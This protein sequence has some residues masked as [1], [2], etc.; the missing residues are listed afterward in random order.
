MTQLLCPSRAELA[1]YLGGLLPGDRHEALSRHLDECAG[2]QASLPQVEGAANP[3][4]LHPAEA[5]QAGSFES[6]PELQQALLRAS[7]ASLLSTDRELLPAATPEAGGSPLPGRI[8][9]YQVL[10]EIARGGM[11]VVYKARQV[12]LNRVVALKMTRAGELASAEETQRFRLEAEAA[13]KLDHPAIVPIYEVGEDN[14]RHYFSMALV[15]G[16]SLAQT[17]AERPLASREAATLVRQVAEA[18][19]YAHAQGVIHRDLK[20]GNIL[21][22][23]GQPRVTDFGLAKRAD[24]DSDLTRTGQI[25]GTPSYMAPEQAEGKVELIGPRSDVYALGATLYC[26]LTGRP[27]FHAA[28]TLETLRQVAERDPVPP[29]QLNAAI[30]PDLETICL[31][32]LEKRPERRY[33]SARELA[34]ELGRFLEGLPIRARPVGALGRAV[35]WWRRRPAIAGLS[36][37][38]VLVALAGVSAVVWQWRK[39]VML[40]EAADRSAEE[41]RQHT[42]AERWQRYRSNIAA[43]LSALRLHNDNA[44]RR[45]LQAAPEE[46]RNWEWHYLSGQLEDTRPVLRGLSFAALSPTS[47]QVAAYGWEDPVIHLWKLATGQRT[48]L[49]GHEA[50]VSPRALNYSPDGTRIA[51]G[52]A[53]RT[54]RLW[55]ART[56]RALAVLRGHTGPVSWVG[57]SPDGKRIASG[58]ASE[59]AL[60]LWD[61]SGISDFRF[62]ISDLFNLKSEIFNLKSPKVLRGH[63]GPVTGLI[64]GAAARSWVSSSADGTVRIW[65]EKGEAS[66]VL[67]GHQHPVV[68]LAVSPDGKRIASADAVDPVIRLWDGETGMEMAR[69][70]GHALHVRL[71]VFSPD[72]SR[73]ASSSEY[74]DTPARLWDG[75]TGKPIA[76]LAE[77]RNRIERLAFSPDGKRLLT[78]GLDSRGLVWDASTGRLLATLRG[79]TRFV[80]DGAFSPD[81]QRIVT[82][83][84]DETVRLWQSESGELISVLHGHTGDVLTAQFTGDGAWIVS[85]GA[86]VCVWETDLATRGA[87]LRG[88]TSY[89][90][91]VTFSPD[92]KTL[93]SAAWDGTARLWDTRTHRQLH[94]LQHDDDI[95]SGVAFSPDRKTLASGEHSCR[96]FLWD[97]ATGRRKQVLPGGGDPRDTRVAFNPKGPELA[98]TGSDGRVRLWDGRSREPVARLPGHQAYGIEVA[99]SPDGRHLISTAVDG[100][101]CVWEVATRTLVTMLR[102][103]K[104]RVQRVAFSKDGRLLATASLDKT[105]RLWEVGSYREVAVLEQGS[106]VYGVAFSPDGTRLAAGCANGTIRLWDVANRTEVA[107][108]H[109]HEDYVH[110]VAF[111]PDGTQLASASGDFT[112]RL[113]DVLPVRTRARR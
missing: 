33:Q 86:D 85:A 76:V 113:W 32:C 59:S 30:A 100:T 26:L 67:R 80:E 66:A 34:E 98:A 87:V 71:M 53:D 20:P 9:D 1:D 74:K 10:E 97:V 41:A 2:C 77:H 28:T 18:V 39:A 83:S 62:Q 61:I 60:R 65:G 57:F 101:A 24:S 43:A 15:E 63:T 17:I 112:V 42:R 37:A 12:S 16:A 5:S 50:R 35:R 6:E 48:R 13:A 54:V 96:V 72:G 99:F 73:L 105:V 94:R 95:V 44:A 103:H 38:I 55:D 102:G 108:L 82:A 56:G 29:R 111:S 78:T 92:G 79:H 89:V 109:G 81:G 68:T 36:A 46:Y 64:R 88:H 69:L 91:D 104:E 11:G 31:K 45:A 51:S 21:L 107:D 52:S 106:L 4:Q 19:A 110:A 7:A 84:L 3:L 27:P 70:K 47:R 75:V 14:G 22:A 90:Y 23:A 40:A 8:G 49:R 25:L 58:S 93:A